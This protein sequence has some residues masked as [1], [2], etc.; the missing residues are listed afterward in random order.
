MNKK[1]LLTVSLIIVVAAIV[2]AVA[3]KSNSSNK[4]TEDDNFA[5]MSEI[6]RLGS[7]ALKING[8][9]VSSDV[10]D[11]EYLLFYEKYKNINTLLAG[12]HAEIINK[13]SEKGSCGLVI[14]D[15]FADASLVKG[16]VKEGG[17]KIFHTTG[18]EKY[19]AVAAASILA[20]AAYLE[21][22]KELSEKF[23]VNLPKGSSAETGRVIQELK[24][25]DMVKALSE[26]A[27][28][29]FSNVKNAG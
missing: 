27:K 18:A 24:K 8:T 29:N 25:R 23:K 9:Y 4:I 16:G 10:F 28:M 1:I 15:Q 22:L 7:E 26:I 3:L 17:F 2:T 14:V 20:R 13:L 19:T 12:R 6:E 11:E 21:G 5:N